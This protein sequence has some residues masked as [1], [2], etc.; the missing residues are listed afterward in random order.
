MAATR[1]EYRVHGYAGM[2]RVLVLG[3]L[4]GRVVPPICSDMLPVSPG[5]VTVVDVCF[6]PD[7]LDR[8]YI[9]IWGYEWI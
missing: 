2:K 7:I 6:V 8:M 4:S 9:C 5:Y 1:W 3:G